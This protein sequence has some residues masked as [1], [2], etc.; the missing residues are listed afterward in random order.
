MTTA[1]KQQFVGSSLDLPRYDGIS[2][3]KERYFTI[4]DNKEQID[5][6]V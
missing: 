2:H 4:K 6:H 1:S 5:L 3:H